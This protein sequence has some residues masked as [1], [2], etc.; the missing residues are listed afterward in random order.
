VTGSSTTFS[1][2]SVGKNAGFTSLFGTAAEDTKTKT[3][4]GAQVADGADLTKAL[5]E[6]AQEKADE[7]PDGT[8]ETPK[9]AALPESVEQINGEE[10]EKRLFDAQDAKLYVF[11]KK[12]GEQPKWQECGRG[13]LHVNKN[14][15][16]GCCRIIMRREKSKQLALN[17]RLFPDMMCNV[18]GDKEVRITCA[19]EDG[20]I[21]MYSVRVLRS[22]G[23]AKQLA[24]VI[25]DNKAQ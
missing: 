9:A 13:S 25:T 19:D 1:S 8:E 11:H 14:T 18:N 10:G 7:K 12:E 22:T 21:Q 16:S 4:F 2:E 24:Q 15:E 3:S 20:A 6:K 23:G 5:Q 17:S